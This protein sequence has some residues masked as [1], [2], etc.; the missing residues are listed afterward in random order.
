[1]KSWIPIALAVMLLGAGCSSPLRDQASIEKDVKLMDRQL[2][3]AAERGDNDRLRQLLQ[4]GADMNARDS[5]GRTAIMAATHGNRP[6]AVKLLIDA[7]ADIN[8][9]DDRRDNPF[10][11]AGAEGRFEILELLIAAKADTKLTNR[12]GGTALIPAAE[13]GHVDNV[14]SL[15]TKTDVDVNHV[16]DLGW[17]ALLEA[18]VLTN[19]GPKHQEIVRLLIAHGADVNIADREGV[20]PLRHAVNRGFAEMEAILREAGAR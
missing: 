18:V 2:I 1:M 13:K 19:G 4:E 20:T 15:L 10:L 6:E 7:G 12:Y 5:R 8:A 16:N 9:Q 17:T 11:Y 3:S 14:R